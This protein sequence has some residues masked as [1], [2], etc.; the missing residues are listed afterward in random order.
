VPFP[1]FALLVIG[2]LFASLKT[3]YRFMGPSWP[4]KLKPQPIARSTPFRSPPPALPTPDYAPA[5]AKLRVRQAWSIR[6]FLVVSVVMSLAP[7]LDG[8]GPDL[9]PPWVSVSFYVGVGVPMIAFAALYFSFRCPHCGA[10][11]MFWQKCP[12]CGIA[13]GA[14]DA[15]GPAPR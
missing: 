2:G 13:V 15:T 7:V 4:H 8:L 1:I 6:I 14:V 3:L 11:G 12:S 10:L 9:I 5:W